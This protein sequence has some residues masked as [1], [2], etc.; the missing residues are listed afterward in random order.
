MEILVLL[1]LLIICGLIWYIKK[2]NE[3]ETAL[4]ARKIETSVELKRTMA[5]G[6]SYRFNFPK[7][8]NEKQEN[9][10]ENSTDLFLKQMP[11]DFEEFVAEIIKSKY[12]GSII[13]T[14]KSGDFG[15]DFE[16]E[17]E[18]GLY[19]GQ[20]K[21]KKH[22]LDF[23]PIA[24]IHSNMVKQG[25]KGGYV[26]T[27]ADFTPAAKKYAE[28]LNIELINGIQLVTY[29]LESMDSKVYEPAEVFA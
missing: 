2:R 24:L 29:W 6:L 12:G 16:Q 25:A 11:F 14:S 27:T 22:D 1:L 13:T 9:V 20:A 3:Q 5:M 18:D 26:I 4:I 7:V 15:V 23:S 17:T 19:L 8:K 21:A 10:Y 28:G